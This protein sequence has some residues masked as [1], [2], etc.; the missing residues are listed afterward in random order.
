MTAY[1]TFDD[2][3]REYVIT[4]PKTPVKWINYLGT[5]AFGGYVDHTG[6]MALCKGDP[7]LNRITRTVPQFP[8]SDF[9]GS[10]LY[11][12]FPQEGGY[13]VFSAFFTPTLDRFDRFECHVGM[14]YSRLV[15]EFYGLRTDALIFVPLGEARVIW[16]VN[17]TNVGNQPRTVDAVPVVEYSHFDA[18][19]QFT[20]A[21]WVPQTVQSQAHQVEDHLILTQY[22]FMFKEARVNYF[23]ADL[24]VAS[25]ESERRRFLGEN[26]YGSW[27]GPLGLQQAQ[28]SGTE[29]RRGD[30]IGALLIPLGT[31]RPGETR[32]FVT[33]LGQEASVEA[34]LPGIRRYWQPGAAEESFA[35]LGAFWDDYLTPIQVS[36]PDPALNS[37]LNVHN[38]RQC[39]VTKNWSRYLSLYQLGLGTRGLGFRDSSQDIMGVVAHMPQEARAFITQILHV[40]RQD[41]SAMHQYNPLTMEG[42]IGDAAE[43][44]DRL[45]YYSDDHLWIILAACAYLKETGDFGLL[46]EAVPYYEK[47]RA[48]Q[49]LES[50][51]VLDHLLRGIEFTRT[52]TGQ[53]G[54]PLLGYADWND[55]VNLLPGAESFFTANLYGVA[56]RELIALAEF[57]GEPALA[58]RLEPYY[59]AMKQRVNEHGWDGEWYIR[60]FDPAGQPVGSS[61]NPAGKIYANGQSWPVLSGFA[62]PQRAAQALDAV[63][64]HLNTARGI[65]LSAPGYNGYDPAIG[66]ISTYP[67]GAK[68][69]GG[70]FLHANPWV[71]IAET[72][73]GRG[74]R[75]YDYYRRINP[76]ARNDQI[77]EYECEPYC[78]PQN[79][80]GDDHPLF[81]LARNSWLSGTAS[82]MYQ[83]GTQY[84]L[85]VRPTYAGLRVDP[86]I[87]AAWG[88]FSVRRRFRGATYVIG[89][90]NPRR[91]NQGVASVTVDGI[92]QAGSVL[93]IFAAG[94]THRVEVV[95]G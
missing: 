77:D 66:G 51:T 19:K 65:K 82:W 46:D 69:N 21:D 4:N 60:Y 84:I 12:R 59:E 7:S 45:H 95:M 48:G 20:N 85:G 30:N 86:C 89:V 6:G 91:V 11:L 61:R 73:L 43:D 52:H 18:L 25:F 68:E 81:G 87:P 38:V 55:T 37:M 5:L 34:A 36:T 72:I 57:R 14:G 27:A 26:E 74:E 8:A 42:Q 94:G 28:L 9:R 3:R 22:A 79:I 44:P 47:D 58:A 1:G 71:I 64:Q 40:Q 24:P 56:L 83:A 33:Q 10:T 88:V 32:R 13:K 31:L 78:Y 39:H 54:L 75:A 23:T 93:P 63:R 50:G 62:T 67:P 76:A 49:P 2:A 53:H 17:V 70:I 16:L 92:P 29:A 90:S 41:G 15:T 80:L 35:A